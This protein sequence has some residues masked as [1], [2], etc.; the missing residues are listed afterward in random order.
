MNFA[1]TLF[2]FRFFYYGSQAIKMVA[3]QNEKKTLTVK[4]KDKTPYTRHT[5]LAHRTI[6]YDRWFV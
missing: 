2:L 4:L 1:L 6:Y 3:Q 5:E